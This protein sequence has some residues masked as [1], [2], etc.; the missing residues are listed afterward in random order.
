[1]ALGVTEMTLSSF[2]CFLAI[3][4]AMLVRLRTVPSEL[5]D[6]LTMARAGWMRHHLRTIEI[7]PLPLTGALILLQ[8]GSE[9][10]VFRGVM[11]NVFQPA[12]AAL[13]VGASVVLFTLM[14]AFQMPTWYSAMFP[15]VGAFVM[16]IVHGVLFLLVP[17]ILPLIVAHLSFLGFAVI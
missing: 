17:D 7:A 8:V 15:M 4:A 5:K 3:K 11:I 13:A 6:W 14:Q 12:G 10:L 9:E 2:L 1:V 16:G